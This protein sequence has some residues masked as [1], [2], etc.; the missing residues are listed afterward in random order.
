MAVPWR[1]ILRLEITNDVLARLL[2]CYLC[3]FLF[4]FFAR[5]EPLSLTVRCCRAHD[6]TVSVQRAMEWWPWVTG[7]T[8][9]L[10]R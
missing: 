9:C 3:G 6:L 8:A 10:G 5:T 4:Q 1:G 2:C 7:C